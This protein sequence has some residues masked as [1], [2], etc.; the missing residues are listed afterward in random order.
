M[1]THLSQA[2]FPPD[3]AATVEADGQRADVVQR[4]QEEVKRLRPLTLTCRGLQRTRLLLLLL[5]SRLLDFDFDKKTCG[6]RNVGQVRRAGEQIPV[7][8]WSSLVS[9]HAYFE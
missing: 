2:L 3:G 1:S 5:L 6:E 4:R 9:R 7:S 8:H